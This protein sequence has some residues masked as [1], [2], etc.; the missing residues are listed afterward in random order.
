M[1]QLANYRTLV[2]QILLRNAEYAP[3]LGEIDSIPVFDERS[4]QYFLVDFGWNRTGRVHSVI[5][6]LQLKNGKVWI[7]RD[8]TEEGIAYDLLEAGIP[9]EDIVLAFY[10]PER[11]AIT[12]FAIA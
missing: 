10:R 12:E 6:H 9:K 7:E 3:S 4:D 2:K 5:L 8:G 1:D 11:R